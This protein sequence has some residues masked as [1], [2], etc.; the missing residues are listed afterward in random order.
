M[1]NPIVFAAWLSSAIFFLGAA[2]F[3][4]SKF[5]KLDEDI[6]KNKKSNIKHR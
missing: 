1:E 5:G 2:W 6:D 4:Y 3:I